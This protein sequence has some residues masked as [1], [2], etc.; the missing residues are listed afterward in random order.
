MDESLLHEALARELIRR[1]QV[2]RSKLNLQM[3]E[4][5][6]VRISTKDEEL[7]TAI[8]KM[9]EYIEGETRAEVSVDQPSGTGLSQEWDIDGKKVVIELAKQEASSTQ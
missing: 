4:R 6:R 8:T 1:I 5:A 3:E 7:L 2:M 9:R